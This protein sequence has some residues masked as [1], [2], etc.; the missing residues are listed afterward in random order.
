MSVIANLTGNTADAANFSSIAAN[1][2]T[3]WESYAI[4]P[5]VTGTGGYLAHTTLSYGNNTSH[6]MS[7]PSSSTVTQT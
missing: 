6:G 3:Q 1:Y 7:A 2:I 5:A 4:A